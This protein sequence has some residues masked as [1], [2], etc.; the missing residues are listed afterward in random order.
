[1]SAVAPL[2][3]QSSRKKID[4]Q[5]RLFAV[6]RA[7]LRPCPVATLRP[8][9]VAALAPQP[10]TGV[11]GLPDPLLRERRVGTEARGGRVVQCTTTSTALVSSSTAKNSRFSS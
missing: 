8:C 11:T 10:H 4:Q 6:M 5:H 9:A 3:A 7:A 1:M 2:R